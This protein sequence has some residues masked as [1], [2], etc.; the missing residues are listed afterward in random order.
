MLSVDADSGGVWL[1]TWHGDFISEWEF[2]EES[3]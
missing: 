1:H 3:S 2:E